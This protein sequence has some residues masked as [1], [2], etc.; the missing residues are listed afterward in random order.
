MKPASTAT[1]SASIILFCRRSCAKRTSDE[2]WRTQ[3]YEIHHA[4]RLFSLPITWLWWG[5]LGLRGLLWWLFQGSLGT[6]SAGGRRP[7]A[8]LSEGPTCGLPVYPPWHHP[9]FPLAMFPLASSSPPR[10]L[11]LRWINPPV[12]PWITLGIEY[13]YIP[14]HPSSSFVLNDLQ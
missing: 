9:I 12:S 5:G 13:K 10:S 3:K 4:S 6:S 7:R 2:W 11:L 14:H 8:G 1:I